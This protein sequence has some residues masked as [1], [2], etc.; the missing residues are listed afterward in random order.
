[1]DPRG[2]PKGLT[3]TALPFRYNHINELKDIIAKHKDD[4]AAI[5][6]EPIRDDE[7]EAGFF[8]EIRSLADETKAVL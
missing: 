1:L 5:V 2:V 4:L 6:M 7:P 8:N 3:G